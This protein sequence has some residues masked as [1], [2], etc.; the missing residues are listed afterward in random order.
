MSTHPV[1][2]T[3]H[4]TASAGGTGGAQ[5]PASPAGHSAGPFARIIGGAMAAGALLA[6]VLGVRL[7]PGWP[8]VERPHRAAARTRCR[9]R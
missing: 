8:G 9:R 7:R 1:R 3:V 2:Q 5:P 4:P 6:L